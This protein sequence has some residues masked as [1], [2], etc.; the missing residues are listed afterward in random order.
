MSLP[1][2]YPK[3]WR[4]VKA[5]PMGSVLSYSEVARRAGFPKGARQVSRALQAAPVAQRLPWHRVVGAQ[6]RLSLPAD[7]EAG[8]I[9]RARLKKEGVHIKGRRIIAATPTSLDQALWG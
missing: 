9:Q 5:I 2:A 4:V 6:G 7:S 8:R 1:D 3:I